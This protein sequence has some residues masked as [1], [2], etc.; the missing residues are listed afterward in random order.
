MADAVEMT[1]GRRTV[2]RDLSFSVGE[3]EVVALMGPSGVG[4]STLLAG[5]GGLVPF[6]AGEVRWEGVSDLTPRIHW[7]F[8]SSPMLA[9]RSALDNVVLA[10]EL[11]HRS[12]EDSL[13]AARSLLESLG[14]SEAASLPAHRL[15]GGERQRV[16]VARAIAAAPNL[17]LADEPTASLDP[18][19]RAVVT[20]SLVSAARR[21][22][23]VIIAPHD[24][25]VA[26][27]CD[28]TIELRGTETVA[29]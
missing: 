27:H 20:E 12:R 17:L 18:S 15:S 4:K 8:Q 29:L 3:G 14:L 11:R 26:D 28:L 10:L 16:A 24:R 2:F 9:R 19:T 6:S 25:W 1:V 23:L 7:M 22:A 21:G 13:A 5:L